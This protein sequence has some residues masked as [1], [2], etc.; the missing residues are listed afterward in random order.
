MKNKESSVRLILEMLPIIGKI[1]IGSIAGFLIFF[2]IHWIAILAGSV[3]AV[4]YYIIPQ[5]P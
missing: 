5:K 3:L 2:G 1:F 4:I